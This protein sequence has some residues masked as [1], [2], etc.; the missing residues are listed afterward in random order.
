MASDFH[1]YRVR[2]RNP[3]AE[4]DL[5]DF[6]SDY[7]GALV[8]LDRERTSAVVEFTDDSETSEIKTLLQEFEGPEVS[9]VR[10]VEVPTAYTEPPIPLTGRMV[11]LGAGRERIPGFLRLDMPAEESLTY[12]VSEELTPDIVA[13]LPNLP[14]DD[15][16]IDV[17]RMKDVLIYLEEEEHETLA[18]EVHRALKPGGYFIVIEL[19]DFGEVF[20]SRL[21]LRSKE[22]AGK[23]VYAAGF[24]TRWVY[25]K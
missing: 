25:Q 16:S 19:H 12:D 5:R 22:R 3:V 9:D 18:K 15:A 24:Y 2:F 8:E 7:E 6:L 14:F 21:T 4:E 17:F 10:R 20:R 1:F 11:N 13:E 23:V